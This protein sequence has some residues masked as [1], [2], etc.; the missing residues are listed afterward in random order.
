MNSLH[1]HPRRDGWV[2]GT[3][4]RRIP[5][6][7]VKTQTEPLETPVHK[8]AA[9][10]ISTQTEVTTVMDLPELEEWQTVDSVLESV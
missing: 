6:Q 4:T 9:I 5:P 1:R 3:N 8:L 2:L 7:S 10:E